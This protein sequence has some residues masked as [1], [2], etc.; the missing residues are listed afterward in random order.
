MDSRYFALSQ[1]ALPDPQ[2]VAA[3]QKNLAML[4]DSARKLAAQEGWT[5]ADMHTPMVEVM[6]RAKAK[7]GPD[8]AFAVEV[9]KAK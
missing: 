1:T 7:Y 4:R 6:G 2:A 8:Y 9:A 5:F 3:T